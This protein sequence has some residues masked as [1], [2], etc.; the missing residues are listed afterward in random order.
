MLK[1]SFD[2]FDW[3]IWYRVIPTFRCRKKT[4]HYFQFCTNKDEVANKKQAFIDACTIT[5]GSDDN[6]KPLFWD[7]RLKSLYST[8]KNTFSECRKVQR[9]VCASSGCTTG[10]ASNTTGGASNTTSSGDW[11]EFLFSRCSK[12]SLSFRPRAYM[13]DTGCSLNIVFFRRF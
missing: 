3:L 9:Y 12:R 11:L 5:F 13:A 4:I 10:G 8:C 6:E 7:N 1:F 2:D